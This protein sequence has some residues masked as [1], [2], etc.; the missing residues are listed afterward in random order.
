MSACPPIVRHSPMEV[1]MRLIVLLMAV[2]LAGM[3]G[4]ALY[5]DRAFFVN[6]IVA[7]AIFAFFLGALVVIQ[8]TEPQEQN[9]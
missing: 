4:L 7:A 5:T 6:D 3:G 8:R 2:Y 1:A 9:R